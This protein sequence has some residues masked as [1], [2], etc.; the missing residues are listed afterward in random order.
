MIILETSR[1]ILRHV[2]RADLD[3][4]A[5]LFAD[6]DVMR[7]SRGPESRE[8]TQRWIEGCIQDYQPDRW[9]FGLWGVVLKSTGQLIGFCGL[10]KFDDV[11]GQ[12]EVEIGYRFAKAHWGQGLAAEAAIATRDYAFSHLGMGRLI[13]LIE[14]DN[15]PSA[16]VAQK[17]GMSLEK[18]VTMWNKPVGV[19]VVSKDEHEL[20]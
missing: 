8:H 7:F 16:R 17:A 4:L 6:P 11:D 10:T 1:L 9:G 19:Y 14:A 18:T 2:T 5:A 15:A 13:S 12:P 20:E 3:P